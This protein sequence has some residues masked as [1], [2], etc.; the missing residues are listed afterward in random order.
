MEARNTRFSLL[1]AGPNGSAS[2]SKERDEPGSPQTQRCELPLALLGESSGPTMPHVGAREERLAENEGLFREVNE[3]VAEVATHNID[4]E[5]ASSVDLTCE[6]GRT[7]CS[8]TMMMTIAEY[9]AIRARSTH[10]GVVPQH[11]Q[12]EIESVI[13]RHPSYFVVEKRE[14]DA[15]EVARETD[16]RA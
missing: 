4:N 2:A 3:R 15:Q 10:F 1:S 12:P 11:E 5:T 16:P 14:L 13:E 9:E 6:C 7:D 8:E